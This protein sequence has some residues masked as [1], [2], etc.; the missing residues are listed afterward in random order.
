M[1]FFSKIVRTKVLLGVED[2]R[3]GR[4]IYAQ[5]E[6]G[7][8]AHGNEVGVFDTDDASAVEVLNRVA[9]ERPYDVWPDEGAFVCDVCNK[10]FSSRIALS[11][12]QR[13]H[14]SPKAES[15]EE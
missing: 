12:H 5:F 8:D 7:E 9:E 10:P 15:T 3:E 13:S 14:K 2:G 1:R 4:P 11:G 6:P